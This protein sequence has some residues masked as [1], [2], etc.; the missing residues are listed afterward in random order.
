MP[1]VL[2]FVCLYHEYT[3]EHVGL[4]DDIVPTTVKTD[5]VGKQDSVM[6]HIKKLS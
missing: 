3:A 2:A 5:R 1:S 4:Q 6:C